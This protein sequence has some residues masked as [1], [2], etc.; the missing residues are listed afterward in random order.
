M[1]KHEEYHLN[2]I[3]SIG[4]LP[5]S[6]QVYVTLKQAI[7][8]GA[9]KPQVKLNEV[10]IA[11]Q[12][13]VSAT[14]VREAFR[15]LAKDNLVVI[16]PWKG[17]TVKGY[18]PE[19]IISMYQCREVMEGLGARLCAEVCTDEQIEELQAVCDAC[20]ATTDAEERVQINSRFHTLISFFSGNDRVMD[21]L[22]EFRE[23]VNR[24]M[25]ISTMDQ[26]RTD[27]CNH[28]HENIMRA[29]RE[30]R[31]EEAEQAMRE[32]IRNAFV[33]KKAHA[34]LR[35]KKFGQANV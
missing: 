27:L 15:K 30:R 18:T 5:L 29:I 17:V 22:G 23:M 31:P 6:E 24:D 1:G 12:L 8:T 33:F 4:R 21:Y 25:Y 32:H 2:T 28:E 13:N 35:A 14:P 9:L 10:K 19:E 11:E 7:L 26:D 3:D 20:L 34:D 16:K